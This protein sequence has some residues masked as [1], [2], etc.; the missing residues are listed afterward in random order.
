M[1]RAGKKTC[2]EGHTFYKTSDCPTCPR[3]EAGK[4]TDGSG[5][6]G[7]GAP[8]RRAL[9][10]QGITTLVKLSKWSERDLLKLHGIG[11]ASLPKLRTAL[12]RAGLKFK[13][14]PE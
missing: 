13:E 7:L 4:V 2:A 11:P 10:G 6:S 9:E 1:A 12:E 14:L 3:C 8:A 5:F